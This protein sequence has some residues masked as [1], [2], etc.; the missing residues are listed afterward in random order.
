MW[1]FSFGF[2]YNNKKFAKANLIQE[3][4]NISNS[5]LFLPDDINSNYLTHD[6]LLTIIILYNFFRFLKQF[7]SKN[8]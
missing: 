5:K 3:I 4:T 8:I 2:F 7:L 1:C 6:Y